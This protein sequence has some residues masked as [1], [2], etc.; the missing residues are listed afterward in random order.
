[1][2]VE[3][4]DPLARE[5]RSRRVVEW[6]G[7]LV[8][9][10]DATVS[11]EAPPTPLV[12]LCEVG[13]DKRGWKCTVGLLAE[14]VEDG[15]CGGDLQRSEPSRDKARSSSRRPRHSA[16]RSSACA[17]T[18]NVTHVRRRSRLAQIVL[19]GPTKGVDD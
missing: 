9:S 17:S 15:L 4:I 18:S 19:R 14:V 5:V 12:D 8:G 10:L 6:T 2:V 13:S 16:R 7:L 1:M 11:N 3:V